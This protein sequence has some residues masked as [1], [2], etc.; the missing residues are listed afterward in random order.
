MEILDGK[1][2]SNKIKNRI[3]EEIS[4]LKKTPNLAVVLIGNDSASQLYV[5]MK[6]KSCEYVGINSIL[7]KFNENVTEI[8]VINKIQELNND[9]N[10]NGILIQLPLPNHINSDKIVGLVNP[11]KDVDGF[12]P[13]NVGKLVTGLNGFVPCTPLGIVKLLDEYQIPIQ[14]KN[15]VIIGASNI[16]G[17]PIASLLL[18][19]GATIEICH[20]YTDDLKKHT[21]QADILIVAVGKEKLIT[22]DMVKNNV[23]IIDVG[24]NKNSNGKIVGDVD[25]DEVSKKASYIT[26]VPKGV[27]PMTIAMLLENTLKATK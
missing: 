1:S 11:N 5:S 14:G 3:K 7:V 4:T 2:L 13:I 22:S 26:P 24:I 12:N 10:I 9:K 20:I 19:R 25:F 23:V 16:V 8:E 17:K 18:N 15:V 6:K 21:L 27:G